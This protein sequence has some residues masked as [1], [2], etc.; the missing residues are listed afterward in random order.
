MKKI[1]IPFAAIASLS[2]IAVACDNGGTAVSCE[3]D[4]DCA[5]E[6]E[7]TVCDLDINTCV[8]PSEPVCADA[9]DCDIANSESPSALTE[10]S[11]DT[12]CDDGELCITDGVGDTYCSLD[13]DGLACSD[14]DASFTEATFDGKTT[15]VVD[16]GNTCDDDGQCV[17]E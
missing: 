3:S 1:L 7:N 8:A 11:A 13:P 9:A 4:D 15:C 14:I 6:A 5:G 12:D 16:S 10:C 2:F 17:A